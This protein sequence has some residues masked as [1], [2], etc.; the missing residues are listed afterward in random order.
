MEFRDGL[1]QED[2]PDR[3][4]DVHVPRA[5]DAV[6]SKP[7][8]RAFVRD[9][10]LWVDC[11]PA[12]DGKFSFPLPPDTIVTRN[13]LGLDSSRLGVFVPPASPLGA[14][15]LQLHDTSHPEP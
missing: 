4:V 15:V 10:E 13:S 2:I 12:V 5:A 3:V 11:L 1:T 9:A 7:Y 6:V 14:F 8:C